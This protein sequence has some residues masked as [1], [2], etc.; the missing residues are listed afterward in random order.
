MDDYRANFF[1]KTISMPR[2]HRCSRQFKTRSSVLKHINQPTSSC[3]SMRT[4]KFTRISNSHLISS[5]RRGLESMGDTA[6][7]IQDQFQ[8]FVFD[9]PETIAAHEGIP[10]PLP[11]AHT[12]QHRQMITEDFPGAAQTFGTGPTFLDKFNMDQYAMERTTNLYYPFASKEEWE[13]ASFLLLSKLSMAAINQMLSLQ[14]IRRVGLSF[15]NARDLRGRAETLPNGPRWKCRT[16]HT[17][18]PTKYPV[19]LFH[20]NPIECIQALLEN[21]VLKNHIHFTPL[22]IFQFAQEQMRV[23][24]EWWTGDAAWSMQG[25]I[26][27]GATLLGTILSSDKTSIS[28]MTGGRA[29]HPLLISLANI[30]GDVRAHSSNHAFV[31]LALLPI[32]KFIHKNQKIRGVLENRLVHECLDIITQPLKKAAEIGVMMTDPLANTLRD[33]Q[34]I[35]LESHIHPWDLKTYTKEAMKYRLN[36]VH[37][38]FF[39]DWPM[40]EP[41]VFLTPELLHHEHKYAW[42]HDVIW[43]RNA[44]GDAEMDFRFSILQPHTGFRHFTEGISK[45]KQVTGRE[46]RDVQRYLVPVVADA[47]PKRFLIAIRASM[48]FR[49]LAQARV[50]NERA[51]TLLQTSLKEFHDSKAAILAAGARQGKRGPI[52]NWHIPKLEFSQSMAP[53]TRLNGAPIHWSADTTE[54]A[55]ITEIKDPARASNNQRYEEQICRHLDRTEKCRLFSMATSMIENTMV[56]GTKI[57]YFDL[58]D[59]L[60]RGEI[61]SALRPLRTFSNGCVALH[62]AHTP[63][64]GRMSID[65][66]ATKF[67]IPDL[68]ALLSTY[69]RQQSAWSTL[70]TPFDKLEIWTKVRIQSRAYHPPYDILPPQTINAS[71]PSASW[72]L[73]HY[74]AILMNDNPAFQWPYSGMKGHSVAQLRVIMRPVLKPGFEPL[75]SLDTFL[76]YVQHFD[77]IPQVNPVF[78]GSR[79]RRGR[80]PEPSTGLYLLKRAKNAD[81]SLR[82]SIVPLETIRAHVELTPRLG[83]EADRRLTKQTSLAYSSEF[84]LDK[85]FNKELFFALSL[86]DCY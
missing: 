79:T 35:E 62:V 53:N 26:P 78:S 12:S 60:K 52:N 21:P 5:H 10:E 32:P 31:L 44:I 56:S 50:I 8:T 2:C 65:A 54:H 18:Y 29:A 4:H 85:Y 81:Q 73:G 15:R 36:G 6:M 39:R 45:L 46:H 69:S 16:L 20:R 48:N 30:S 37:R 80:F 72:P 63:R 49:Y 17:V 84:W 41:S 42:D 33:L 3:R 1:L 82:G 7:E 58:A 74:D 43:C 47:V 86:S 51:C 25:Q 76:A 57:D 22:H 28:V 71:P 83:E 14:L 77:I 9:Q 75:P 13:L 27:P 24:S 68:K 70:H 55:H 59:R 66:I 34:K 61:P 19:H 11:D 40:S 23:Y 38:P 67:H 64:F